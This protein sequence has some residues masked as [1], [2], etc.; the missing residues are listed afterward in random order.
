MYLQETL[1]AYSVDTTKKADGKLLPT[2]KV[3][4]LEK[5]A[6]KLKVKLDGWMQDGVSSMLY[7]AKGERIIMAAFAKK[8]TL[9]IKVLKTEKDNEGK[10]DWNHVEMVIFIDDKNLVDSVEP[11]YVKAKSLLEEQCGLCHTTHPTNEFTANQWPAV[12]KG[13]QGRT[14][15]S[16]E[17]VLLITQYAQKHSKK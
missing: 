6:D 9:D 13:M 15:L 7:F 4:I 16:S 3:E 8:S 5:H 14:A 10:V 1:P 2:T 17:D 11:L 12:I